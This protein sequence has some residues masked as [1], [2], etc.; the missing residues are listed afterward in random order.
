MKALRVV[1]GALCVSIVLA[2]TASAYTY[3]AGTDYWQASTDWTPASNPDD[4]HYGT[5]NVWRY[6]YNTNDADFNPAN[7]INLP[8]WTGSLWNKASSGTGYYCMVHSSGGHPE[9]AQDSIRSWE[10]PVYGQVRITGTLAN[11]N[12]NCGDGIRGYI[13][14]NSTQ[15]W[16]GDAIKTTTATPPRHTT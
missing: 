7:H 12:P 15:V 10:S 8:N 6:Q 5:A 16:T 11:T 1:L 9:S 2:G 13:H 3:V 4:D 14:Q